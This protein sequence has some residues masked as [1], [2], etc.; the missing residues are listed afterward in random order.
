MITG[1]VAPG[2][3]VCARRVGHAAAGGGDRA[4]KPLFLR[5]QLCE[6]RRCALCTGVWLAYALA[7]RRS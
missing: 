1:S 2:R 3:V 4:S 6:G 7:G 5:A